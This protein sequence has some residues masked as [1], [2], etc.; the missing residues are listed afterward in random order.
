MESLYYT[1]TA[2]LLYFI[3]DRVLQRIEAIHGSRFEHRSIIFF[4]LLL[5]L[6]ISCFA[7]I[8]RFVIP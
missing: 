5:A 1:I 2:V 6:A 4:V 3:A 8:R 7:L